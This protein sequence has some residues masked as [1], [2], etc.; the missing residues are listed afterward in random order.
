V[1]DAVAG[2]PV[3]ASDLHAVLTGCA[4][5]V[6]QPEGRALGSDWRRVTDTSGGVV[7]MRRTGAA[8]PWQL[9]T[10]I[11]SRWRADF[12]DFLNGLPRSMRITGRMMTVAGSVLASTYL[13]PRD[14]PAS[15]GNWMTSP[16][17]RPPSV[18]ANVCR[19]GAPRN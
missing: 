17:A 14:E 10:V 12:R 3:S 11:G 7:Y 1:L 9:V 4:P 2:V 19:I 13:P 18:P 16:I 8:Q 5:A 6:S 15:S